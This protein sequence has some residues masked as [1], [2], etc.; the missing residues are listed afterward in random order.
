MPFPRPPEWSSQKGKAWVL[1]CWSL[2]LVVLRRSSPAR[3]LLQG[4]HQVLLTEEGDSLHLH[5]QLCEWQALVHVQLKAS[6]ERKL[7]SA[8]AGQRKPD[9]STAF[10]LTSLR[11]HCGLT[12]PTHLEILKASVTHW[13]QSI[14]G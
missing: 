8:Q 4:T 7:L 3:D 9:C 14:H 10:L 12:V 11:D 13:R 2:C 1:M 5:A 6:L